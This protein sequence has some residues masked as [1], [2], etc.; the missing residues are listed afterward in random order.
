MFYSRKR[1]Y[2]PRRRF[3]RKARKS[4]RPRRRYNRSRKP[5]QNGFAPL[6]MK[7]AVKMRYCETISQNAGAGV[8]AD[9]CFSANGIYDPNITGAGHQP[10]GVDTMFTMYDHGTVVG[11]KI[12][13]D[14]ISNGQTSAYWL[15]VALRDASAGLGGSAIEVVK[16][17]PGTQWRLANYGS[18]ARPCSVSKTFSMKKFF[19]GS[20][21]GEDIYQNTAAANPTDQAYYHVMVAPTDGS[22]LA[23]Q[24]F[25]V[26]IDYYVVFTEPKILA[27][28]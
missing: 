5:A 4:Y 12:R 20:C 1:K 3:Q 7:Q 2:V 17:Q 10:Y 28:S 14:T 15:G 25:T 24:Y 11:S 16:E 19:A 26:T 27:Q 6:G 18:S 23:A 13:V 8:I 21:F 9:Y 22:D